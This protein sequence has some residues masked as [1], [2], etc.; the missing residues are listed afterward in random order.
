MNVRRRM[1]VSLVATETRG[2]KLANTVRQQM[3]AAGPPR[4]RTRRSWRDSFKKPVSNGTRSFAIVMRFRH[5]LFGAL[6]S[7]IAV[8]SRRRRRS[9]AF[10]GC[11]H[12]HLGDDFIR[13][14]HPI[15]WN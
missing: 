12:L 14:Q 7:S 6:R 13:W 5:A 11:H 3:Q 15:H 10:F 2:K 9:F 1:L 4:A 8:I